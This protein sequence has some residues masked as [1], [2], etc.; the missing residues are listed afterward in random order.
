MKSQTR[1]DIPQASLDLEGQRL[2]LSIPGKYSLDI[3]RD[4]SDADIQKQAKTALAAVN[5]AQWM[6]LKRNPRDFDVDGAKAEWRVS[7]GVLVV[8]A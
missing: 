1:T 2:I 8:H 6:A 3:D 4:L 7:E 5:A